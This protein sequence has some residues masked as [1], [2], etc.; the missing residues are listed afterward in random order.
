MGCVPMQ[1]VTQ[2]DIATRGGSK[3]VYSTPVAAEAHENGDH[4]Y[5]NT[6]R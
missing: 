3:L 6:S 4:L 2:G 1:A 5:G